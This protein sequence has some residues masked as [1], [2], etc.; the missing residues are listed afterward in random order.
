V[1]DRHVSDALQS[2]IDGK[3]ATEHEG[4]D[5]E[6][7]SFLIQAVENGISMF[8]KAMRFRGRARPHVRSGLQ[9]VMDSVVRHHSS[10]NP[11]AYIQFINRFVRV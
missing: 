3:S 9:E 6:C 1:E 7:V 5:L 10:K 8:T 2:I 4:A 11:R